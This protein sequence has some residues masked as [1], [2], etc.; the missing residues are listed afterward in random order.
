MSNELS[1][2]LSDPA[3]WG[4]SFQTSFVDHLKWQRRSEVNVV[5]K[6]NAVRTCLNYSQTIFILQIK[7]L[8][9][10][11]STWWLGDLPKVTLASEDD[12]WGRPCHAQP[13][14]G[15]LPG[16]GQQGPEIHLQSLP[17]WHLLHLL[18]GHQGG[19]QSGDQGG[20]EPS[21]EEEEKE[22]GTRREKKSFCKESLKSQLKWQLRIRKH[23]S[24]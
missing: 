23:L 9:T 15:S 22:G 21:E 11:S 18:P 8:K 7:W 14:P 6:V 2:T 10:N 24:S 13:V 12:H 1:E 4:C 3:V 5:N 19:H 16:T 20:E 17:H